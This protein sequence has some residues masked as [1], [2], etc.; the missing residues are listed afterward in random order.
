VRLVLARTATLE[1][2]LLHPGGAPV[3]DDVRVAY[4]NGPRAERASLPWDGGRLRMTDLVP[5]YHHV[6]V[7]AA[8]LAPTTLRFSARPGE[9]VDLGEVRTTASAVVVGRVLDASGVPV[10]GAVVRAGDGSREDSGQTTTGG[11]GRFELCGPPPGRC[12]VSVTAPGHVPADVW[13]TVGAPGEPVTVTLHAMA[14]LRG[15]V[16]TA[17][18]LAVPQ[19]GVRLFRVS[20]DGSSSWVRGFTSDHRGVFSL[21]VAPGRY[22]F[23]VGARDTPPPVRPEVELRADEP[24]WVVVRL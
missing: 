14:L 1:A 18:G 11:D 12:L 23:G 5:G 2:L 8:G 4:V 10:A 20:G 21:H 19:R 22:R 16:L 17:D 9:T 3:P 24:V 13:A 15:R 7:L 6:R